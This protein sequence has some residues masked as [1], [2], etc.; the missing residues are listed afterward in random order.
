MG[1]KIC[2]INQAAGLGDIILCQKI[3]AHV[4]ELGYNIV[5]PVVDQ[6][7]YISEYIQNPKIHFCSINDNFIQKDLYLKN[8]N[9]FIQTDDFL[10][11]PLN[12]ADRVIQSKSMLYAKYD[13]CQLTPDN[14][15]NHFEI[16]RN[17]SREEKLLNHFNIIPGEK[18][19]VLNKT[20]A[21]PPNIITNTSIYPKNDYKTINMELLGWD[22]I[23]DWMG[24][25]EGAEEIHT[26]DTSLTLI[27]TK[28]NVKN[29]HIYERTNG[30]GADY[31]KPNPDYIHRSLFC[32]DWKYYTSL[33][34]NG[35]GY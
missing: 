13:Y 9:E 34:K 29:V 22:R 1:N 28:L 11:L 14:W 6:Y 4:I 21:T 17:Y 10:Y 18:Y 32:K 15:Q 33:T 31:S 5:W 25:L 7:N 24:I 8:E 26:V 23:F 20:F 35:F 30:I 2:L 27:L 12:N 16:K 3:A 19:N